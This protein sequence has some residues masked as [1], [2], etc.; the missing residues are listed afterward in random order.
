MLKAVFRSSELVTLPSKIVIDS[1]TS[2]PEAAHLTQSAEPAEEM[3]KVEEYKGP[4]AEELRR[5][6]EAFKAQWEEEKEKLMNSAKAEAKSIVQEA[7]RMAI[8]EEQRQTNKVNTLKQ[9]SEAEAEKITSDARLWAA[10]KEKEVRQTLDAELKEAKDK[11]KEEGYSTGYAQ[12]KAEVDR[13]VERTH[14]MLERAQDKRGDILAETEQ[15]IVDLVLLISRKIIKVITENQRNVIIS[16]VIQALRKV[17]GRGNVI[18]RVNLKD[19]QLTTEHKEEFIKLVEGVKSINVVED[20]TVDT[21]GCIIETDFGEIDARISSQLAELENKILEIS[22]I[23]SR[24]KMKENLP[25]PVIRPASLN[26]ELAATSSLM[27]IPESDMNIPVP[28]MNVPAPETDS[29]A[30][31]MNIS[32]PGMSI[33]GPQPE[34]DKEGAYSS[35]V[36]AALTASAAMAAIATIA[37]K[38]KREG[39]RKMMENLEKIGKRRTDGQT[40]PG[41]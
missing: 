30:P 3:N 21:G 40:K 22:P 17:R 12:G 4:T 32:A 18:I 15:E 38:G 11:G 10:E 28:D 26:T 24:S 41:N 33:F 31:E 25:P 29:S 14:V 2:Y 1:P 6:A 13:L 34:S 7:Q 5:E 19:L 23:K 8:E 37:A 39:D 35:E 36:N 9:Q 20:S 16:N 27:N